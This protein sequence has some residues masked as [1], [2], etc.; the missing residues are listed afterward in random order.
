[1]TD[2]SRIEQMEKEHAARVTELEQ[3]NE[4]LRKRLAEVSASRSN[5]GKTFMAIAVI[6][7]GVSLIA[8]VVFAVALRRKAPAFDLDE[9]ARALGGVSLAGCG[10][11]ATGHVAIDFASD[12]RVARAMV[13]PPLRG[14]PAGACVEER[15]R[16]VHVTPF[17]GPSRPIDKAFVIP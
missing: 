15:F 14:T 8:G 4:R 1:V 5:A 6:T 16:A 13:D 3:E 10:A 9:A 2:P 17:S 12:G 11:H 7:L